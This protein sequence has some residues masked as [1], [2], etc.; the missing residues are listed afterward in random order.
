ME[1]QTVCVRHQVRS[2]VEMGIDVLQ[3]DQPLCKHMIESVEKLLEVVQDDL[4]M[5]RTVDASQRSKYF[6]DG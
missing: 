2:S 1:Q 5:H 4:V 6:L 3:V